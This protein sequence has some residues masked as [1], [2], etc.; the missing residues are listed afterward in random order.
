MVKHNTNC[1]ISKL[2]FVNLWVNYIKN[3][4]FASPQKRIVRIEHQ[5]SESSTC[6]AFYFPVSQ[7]NQSYEKIVSGKCFIH[8]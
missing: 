3:L 6:K 4:G 1:K 7:D 2:N 5:I 8:H